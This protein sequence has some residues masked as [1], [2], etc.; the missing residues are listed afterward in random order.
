MKRSPMAAARFSAMLFTLSGGILGRQ[1]DMEPLEKRLEKIK[2]DGP[3]FTQRW[4][5]V[6][7]RHYHPNVKRPD[8]IERARSERAHPRRHHS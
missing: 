4:R 6:S 7:R 5:A 3:E 8:Q 1:K 2:A